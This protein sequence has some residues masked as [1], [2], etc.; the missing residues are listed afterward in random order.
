MERSKEY[1]A[2]VKISDLASR[3]R[4]GIDAAI[5]VWPIDNSTEKYPALAG[6]LTM[7]LRTGAATV[8]VN[9]TAAEARDLIAA[10]QWAQE[11][12]EQVEAA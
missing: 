10:L 6:R 9:P 12:A 2:D 4:G 3:T 11:P 1:G 8:Q 5:R 7:T